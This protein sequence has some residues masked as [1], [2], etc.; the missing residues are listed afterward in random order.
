MTSCPSSG[1]TLHTL[2]SSECVTK[3]NASANEYEVISDKKCDT[4]CNKPKVWYS[5]GV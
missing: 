2:S 4:D 5:D 3:C 1:E